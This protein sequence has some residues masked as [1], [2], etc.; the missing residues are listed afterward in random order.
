[1]LKPATVPFLI[2]ALSG[3]GMAIQGTLNS[4]LSQ[5]TSLLAATLVIHL[6]GTLSILIVIILGRIP[7]WHYDWHA[8]PWYLY[9]GGILS[10]IIIALVAVSIP[11]I[12]VANATTAIIIGQV[13]TAVLLDHSGFFGLTKVAWN[14]WQ[15]LGVLLMAGGAKLLFH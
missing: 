14:P 10:V 9:L 4:V 8:I 13:T 5:K 15:I 7:V 6:I 1:M 2:A 11:R 3:I 12:G